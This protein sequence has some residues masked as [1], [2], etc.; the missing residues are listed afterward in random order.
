MIDLKWIDTWNKAEY[1][2]RYYIKKFS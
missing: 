2:Y 1:L